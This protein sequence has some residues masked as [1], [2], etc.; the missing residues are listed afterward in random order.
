M[1]ESFQAMVWGDPELGK[2]RVVLRPYKFRGARTYVAEMNAGRFLDFIASFGADS[3]EIAKSIAP[4][5]AVILEDVELEDAGDLAEF[6]F[7]LEQ[8]PMR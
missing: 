1:A 3:G 7:T 4:Q 5:K 2:F 8:G 6:G